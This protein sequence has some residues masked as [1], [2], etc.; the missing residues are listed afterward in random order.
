M[1]LRDEQVGSF[2]DMWSIDDALLS[3]SN[4][5]TPPG[6]KAAVNE[7]AKVLEL[8]ELMDLKN[9][10]DGT[11]E[12]SQMLATATF[13]LEPLVKKQVVFSRAEYSQVEGVKTDFLGIGNQ[14]TWHGSPDCRCDTV[15]VVNLIPI[16]E[17]SDVESS[18]SKTPIE[19][20]RTINVTHVHQVVGNVV[21]YSF[22]HHHCHPHQNP[23]VPALGI[24]GGHGTFIVAMYDCVRDVLC[25]TKPCVWFNSLTAKLQPEGILM[26]WL[27]LYHSLFLRWLDGSE[28]TSRLHFWFEA[29]GLLK[30]YQSLNHMNVSYWPALTFDHGVVCRKRRRLSNSNSS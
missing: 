10:V 3:G 5:K 14:Y 16:P 7:L 2:R 9:T 8:G 17:D 18:G 1:R 25:Y 12:K 20:K 24:S 30:Q 21:T 29:D 19:M 28:A 22:V 13:L 26:I 4:L 27:T 6:I 15:D 23:L 11:N